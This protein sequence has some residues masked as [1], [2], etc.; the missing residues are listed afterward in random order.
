V[1]GDGRAEH[2]TD[3]KPPN[4]SVQE[5]KVFLMPTTLTRERSNRNPRRHRPPSQ[6]AAARIAAIK[7]LER[8]RIEERAPGADVCE[9]LDRRFPASALA[10]L[11]SRQLDRL[12]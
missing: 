3:E 4:A 1:E 9:D 12:R 5:N 7:Q 8:M 2:R 11:P 6:N 10:E